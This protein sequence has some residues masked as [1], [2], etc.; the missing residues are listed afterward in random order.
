[1]TVP[2][3]VRDSVREEAGENTEILNVQILKEGAFGKMAAVQTEDR[4]FIVENKVFGRS[5]TFAVDF[6]GPDNGGG[7]GLPEVRT[8]VEPEPTSQTPDDPQ[9]GTPVDTTGQTPSAEVDTPTSDTEGELGEPVTLVEGIGETYESYLN[10]IGIYTLSDLTAADTESVAEEMGLSPTIVG[11]W[12]AQVELTSLNG[13]GPQY[14]ELLVR[15][16][17]TTIADLSEA[18]PANLLRAVNR[19]QQTL[20]VNIQGNVIGPKRVAGWIETARDHLG[21]DGSV[22]V[23]EAIDAEQVAAEDLTVINGIGGTRAEQLVSNGITTVT[24]LVEA[25]AETLAETLGVGVG[26]VEGW[27]DQADLTTINGIGPR[28]AE[29][30]NEHGIVVTGQLVGA[31]TEE[32]AEAL[33]VS[34]S[35]VE[36]WQARANGSDGN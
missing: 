32:I 24:E 5:N 9:T 26:V 30:L 36:T 13:I 28:R 15:S 19:K 2:E 34:V 25:D 17:V 14:A 12:Q 7:T 33:G 35:Q 23:P 11:R 22:E 10:N 16:G 1:M 20:E 29:T 3:W 6:L 4:G 18:D 8:T 21:L 31:D 27:Q